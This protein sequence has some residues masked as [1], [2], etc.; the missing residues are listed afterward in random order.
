[1]RNVDLNSLQALH[2]K[3][4]FGLMTGD[5]MP[6]GYIKLVIKNEIRP[7][8]LYCYLH[9]KYGPPNGLQN[10][11]RSDDSDNLIH[12][13]WTL[14]ESRGLITILGLSF[15]TEVLFL[16]A[17]VEDSLGPDHFVQSVKNDFVNYGKQMSEIRKGLLE[18]WTEF[19][20]PFNRI[21]SA[22]DSLMSELQSLEL[23]PDKGKDLELTAMADAKAEWAEEFAKCHR[24]IGL[25]FGI[26]SMLP[27]LAEAFINLLIYILCRPDIKSDQRLYDNC[28]RQPID[29]KIKSLHINCRGFAT[30]VDYSSEICGKYHSIVNERNDLLHG[31]VVIEKLAFGD[32]YFNRTVPVF[33]EYRSAWEKSIGFALELAG[34]SKVSQEHCAVTNMID[35]ILSCLEPPIQEEVRRLLSTRDLGANVKTG[36]I[37]ILFPNHLVDFRVDIG[38]E[39]PGNTETA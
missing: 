6:K 25:C 19:I 26:R 13:D 35:Y 34:I 23:T 38:A 21:R 30:A 22:V 14:A 27:V 2:P 31:N 28:L 5:K 10:L 11:F 4:I 39:E 20:N 1:M 37:G 18:K 32:V 16:G 8:D 3:C 24:G 15:R 29:V 7:V 17:F 9:A 36:R 33:T 12:W